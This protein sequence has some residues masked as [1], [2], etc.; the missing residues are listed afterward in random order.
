MFKR[1]TILL[2]CLI[3]SGCSF[4]HVHKQDIV[5]GNVIT[6]SMVNRLD[7]GMSEAEVRDVMGTPL[8][9]NVFAPGR[10]EYVYTIQPGGQS[11]Q[12]TKV[13]CLFVHGRLV[14]IIR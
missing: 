5:Q 13:T 7:K 11:M 14:E 12:E 6:P 1:C 2:A 10:I 9:T 4:F 3:L 8:V